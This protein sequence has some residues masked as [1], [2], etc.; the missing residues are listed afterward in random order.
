MEGWGGGGV[1]G[2]GIVIT[3]LHDAGRWVE[4]LRGIDPFHIKPLF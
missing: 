4:D 1:G 2:G 3:P